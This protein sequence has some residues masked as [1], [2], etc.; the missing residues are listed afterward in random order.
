MAKLDGIYAKM[1]DYMSNHP[2]K[3]VAIM[4][5]PEPEDAARQKQI[6]ERWQTYLDRAG[7]KKTLRA[8][9]N[10]LATGG[11]GLT[12]P[13]EDPMDFDRIYATTF[14]DRNRYWDK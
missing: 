7:H 9:R 4:A 2:G 10:H 5:R 1:A 6:W 13:C 14:S 12:L 3:A 8:W 11:K